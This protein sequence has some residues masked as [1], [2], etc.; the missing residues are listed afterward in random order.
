M[1]IIMDVKCYIL[2]VLICIPLMEVDFFDIQEWIPTNC[3]TVI[4]SFEKNK[5]FLGTPE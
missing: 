5:T 3:K 2:V 1:T 4:N